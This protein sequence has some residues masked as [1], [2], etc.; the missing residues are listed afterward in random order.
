MFPGGAQPS[1]TDLGSVWLP[2]PLPRGDP[3]PA[4]RASRGVS[5]VGGH[6]SADPLCQALFDPTEKE[7]ES[8]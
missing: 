2:F 6:R 5:T 7:L 8:F 3:A 1:M 4:T